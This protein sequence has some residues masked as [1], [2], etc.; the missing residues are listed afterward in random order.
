MSVREMKNGGSSDHPADSCQL[1]LAHNDR[2]I[3]ALFLSPP[4]WRTAAT[5]PRL[6]FL[7]S[8]KTTSHNFFYFFYFIF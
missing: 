6:T 3:V 8:R 2:W 7:H 1:A 4:P 5:F